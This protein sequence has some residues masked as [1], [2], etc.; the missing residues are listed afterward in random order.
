MNELAI[1]WVT[2]GNEMHLQHRVEEVDALPSYISTQVHSLFGRPMRG[3]LWVSAE[4]QPP[5]K[6]IPW[7]D[8]KPYASRATE[9]GGIVV[10]RKDLDTL[11]RMPGFITDL[12]LNLIQELN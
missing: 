6:E 1:W 12:N 2:P 5:L 4:I 11:S 3:R 8:S 7:D 9:S 10:Y